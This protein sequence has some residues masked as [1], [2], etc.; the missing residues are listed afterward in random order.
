MPKV[1]RMIE[2]YD[3]EGV[4]E[5]LEARWTDSDDRWSLRDLAAFFNQAILEATLK[6]SESPMVDGELENIYRLLTDDGVNTVDKTRAR[7]KLER[8]GVDPNEVLEDFV[9]YQ[10]IRTYLKEYRHVEYE[11]NGNNPIEREKVNLQRL[12]G[13]MEAVANSTVSQLESAGELTISD[14]RLL[15]DVRV[16]CEGCN[17]RYEITELLEAGG[18]NCA[19]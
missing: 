3:L 15:V 18:C 14:F 16:F 5:T 4:G 17:E 8:A 10:A 6:G 2:K 12:Q 19:A 9:S 13:R 7:R 11:N 1:L